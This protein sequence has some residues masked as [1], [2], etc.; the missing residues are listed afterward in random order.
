MPPTRFI[1]MQT[2]HLMTYGT[3]GIERV[4]P[5]PCQK[6]Y[7]LDSPHAENTHGFPPLNSL[8]SIAPRQCYR[9]MWPLNEQNGAVAAGFDRAVEKAG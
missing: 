5:P 9:L 3:F 2:H 1:V 4:K 7:E 6:L 8:I